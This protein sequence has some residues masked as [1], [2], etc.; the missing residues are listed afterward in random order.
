MIGIQHGQTLR[1]GI[2]SE[3][4]R[5]ADVAYS[6]LEGQRAEIWAPIAVFV[7]VW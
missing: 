4:L 7:E 6:R 3:V 5:Y 1:A 2:Q